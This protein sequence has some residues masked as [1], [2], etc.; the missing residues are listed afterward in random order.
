MNQLIPGRGG[1]AQPPRHPGGGVGKL[2]AQAPRQVQARI[3]SRES[4]EVLAGPVVVAG[5]DGYPL[6]RGKGGP[7]GVLA[8]R[9]RRRS[10]SLP[11]PRLR[12]GPL[13][14]LSLLPPW[15]SLPLPRLRPGPIGL[16]ASLR[17][18]LLLAP[19]LLRKLLLLLLLRKLLPLLP[20]LPLLP[21]A[22]GPLGPAVREEAGGGAGIAIVR[23]LRRPGG[24]IRV[25]I[26][27]RIRIRLAFQGGDKGVGLP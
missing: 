9:L 15:L 17:G 22:R 13:G 4:L 26:S 19:L 23:P 2:L 7:E 24:W 6:C 14:L 27:I 1:A 10:M 16:L 3:R 8:A 20:V 25:R 21:E 18:L 11:L 5:P 12:P